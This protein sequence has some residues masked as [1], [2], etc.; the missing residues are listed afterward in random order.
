MSGGEMESSR[1]SRNAI[2][3]PIK[4]GSEDE[5]SHLSSKSLTIPKQIMCIQSIAIPSPRSK[6]TAANSGEEL[7]AFHSPVSAS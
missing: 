1:L 7:E 4:Y 6:P 3:S 5:L 2:L